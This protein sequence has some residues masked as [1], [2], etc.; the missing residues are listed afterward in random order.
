MVEK[1]YEWEIQY[2]DER[3]KD[4]EESLKGI[5][6]EDGRLDRYVEK[7]EA[8]YIWQINTSFILTKLIQEAGRWCEYHASDLFIFWNSIKEK[9]EDG[10][11][12]DNN[13]VFAMYAGGV[14]NKSSYEKQKYNY[15][16]YRAVW[17]LDVTVSEDGQKIEMVLHK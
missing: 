3:I 6:R 15:N 14:D 11:L 10:T 13:F 5:I 9:I 4:L 16:H 12:R 17:F 2:R 8:H 1:D 7:N